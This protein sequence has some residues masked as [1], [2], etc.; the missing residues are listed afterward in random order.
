MGKMELLFTQL[1]KIVKGRVLGAGREIIGFEM[2]NNQSM[3]DVHKATEVEGGLPETA[4]SYD[5]GRH[6]DTE[7]R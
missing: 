5:F 6:Q 1:R 7:T 4:W 3:G 2:P